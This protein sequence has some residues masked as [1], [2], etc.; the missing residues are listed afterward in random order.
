M[1]L[2]NQEAYQGSELS[3]PFLLPDFLYKDR[4]TITIWL[5]WL[6][7]VGLSYLTL[8][9]QNGFEISPQGGAVI[10]IAVV[11]NAILMSLPKK[12]FESN[13]LINLLF[14]GD[15]TFM[16]VAL[17]TGGFSSDSLIVFYFLVML[18]MTFG[19]DRRA[20]FF[21]GKFLSVSISRC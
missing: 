15:S 4:K 8:S 20:L 6:L 5:R 17:L 2:E 7:V 3:E 11:S 14:V 13:L 10:G 19:K 18:I 12:L 16:L 9:V 1:P 21:N